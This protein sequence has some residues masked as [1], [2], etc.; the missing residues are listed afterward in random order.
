[1]KKWILIIGIV[2]FCYPALSL[3]PPE[4]VYSVHLGIY[5]TE[6]EAQAAKAGFE[7]KGLDPVW[8][9]PWEG[10]FRLKFGYFPTT[11]EAY[12][13]V[14]ELR[15]RG[16]SLDCKVTWRDNLDGR[17]EFPQPLLNLKKELNLQDHIAPEDALS[18]DMDVKITKQMIQDSLENTTPILEKVEQIISDRKDDDPA[19]GWAIMTLGCLLLAEKE[20]EE[21]KHLFLNMRSGIECVN[22]VERAE[23]LFQSAKIM[24]TEEETAK[25]KYDRL[26]NLWRD[27][28]EGH[29]GS[30]ASQR[31]EAMFLLARATHL[32]QK[33][34]LKAFNIYKEIE[35]IVQ[36]S[37]LDRGECVVWQVQLLFELVQCDMG[38]IGDSRGFA[39]AALQKIPPEQK[40]F[41]ALI[42]LMNLESYL[43]S[44]NPEDYPKG[45]QL[46]EEWEKKYSEFPREHGTCIVMKGYFYW[47]LY[48]PDKSIQEHLRLREF[49]DNIEW[50]PDVHCKEVGEIV[51]TNYL[52]KV[53][54]YD[55]ARAYLEEILK[56][57]PDTN[58]TKRLIRARET[59]KCGHLM[60]DKI[61]K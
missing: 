42:E 35:E 14:R 59:G 53:G 16:I 22:D 18:N 54:R 39:K 46:C 61:Y 10:K 33:N 9:M 27:V 25:P 20:R 37:P 56:K 23:L 57:Y 17:T 5:N 8:I 43:W 58:T 26:L 7:A 48:D 52:N 6:A 2:L 45:L 28:A 15:N 29:I 13:F 11:V 30:T 51:Y 38:N 3:D 49:D 36:S 21:I 32:F 31:L 40:R 12:R 1:M 4:K 34:R 60:N 50:Y 44:G 24:L 47:R 41:H 55:E 19:K